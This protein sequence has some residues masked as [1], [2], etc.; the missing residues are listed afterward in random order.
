MSDLSAAAQ[1]LGVPEAIVQRSAQ[2]RAVETGMSVD[3]VL[4][5]WAGGEA[6]PAATATATAPETTPDAPQEESPEP[7]SA[8]VEVLPS[9]PPTADE[10]AFLPA[11]SL[12]PAGSTRPA[13]RP[14]VLVGVKDNPM[15]VF[16]GAF[17][18]FAAM[19]LVGL[20]GPSIQTENPGARTS[21]IDFSD[22]A[23]RGREV[24]AN[25]GC[26]S[27]HTQMVRPVTADVGLGAVTLNDSNQVLGARRFGPDLSNVGVRLTAD[28]L[29]A[30][31]EGSAGHPRLSLSEGDLADLVAYLSE[32]TT[33]S[34]SASGQGSSS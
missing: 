8:P 23:S 1:A 13:G 5:L 4:S 9:P 25:V 33:L 19:M 3:E 26:A 18:V 17:A 11:P 16:L 20:V 12:A 21:A 24:Y 31:V 10:P 6:A 14:P 29:S 15:L 30:I 22:S 2:A 7:A 34:S 28:Q 27:C 32:S